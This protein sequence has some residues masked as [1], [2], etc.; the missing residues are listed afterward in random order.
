MDQLDGPVLPLLA[1]RMT[2][3]TVKSVTR[4][5][6]GKVEGRKEVAPGITQVWTARHGGF[7][8]SRRLQSRMP[9]PFRRKGGWYE[10][11]GE[12]NLVI[13]AFPDIFPADWLGDARTSVK[14]WFP[15][16]YEAVTGEVIPPG[17]SL[18]KDQRRFLAEHAD[19]FLVATAWG[20]WHPS[21]PAGQVGVL[22][23]RPADGVERYF[24]VP[25]GE[26]EACRRAG[27][28]FVVDPTRHPE[29]APLST[30]DLRAI[31]PESVARL[32]ES[33]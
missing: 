1:G 25:D 10:E 26:Y 2:M 20:D 19:D 14:N 3:T 22:G 33:L 30:P 11:D 5:P 16:D 29:V 18:V 23:R 27:R 8:L 12:V 21:V 13:L 24:L 17:E 6:W 32:F 15:D 9:A 28:Q 7:K 4:S 31:V